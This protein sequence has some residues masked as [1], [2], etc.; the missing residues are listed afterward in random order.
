MPSSVLRHSEESAPGLTDHVWNLKELVGL[1]KTSQK[2]LGMSSKNLGL[3][4]I[5][6]SGVSVVLIW[7]MWIF[8]GLMFMVLVTVQIATVICSVRAARRGSKLWLLAS[9]W[10]ALYMVILCISI[11]AE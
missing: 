6:L 10:P 9:I 1:L 8:P 7:T 3:W 4:S 2:V 11:F 5:A